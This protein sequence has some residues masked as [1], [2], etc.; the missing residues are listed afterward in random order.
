MHVV[1]L[2]TFC[3][4]CDYPLDGLHSSECPE[5]GQPF[6]LDDL[7]TFNMRIDGIGL[8]RARSLMEAHT[9]R[10]LLRS[11][12]VLATVVHGTFE[13]GSSASVWVD[14]QDAERALQVL[15]SGGRVG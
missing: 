1:S 12:D 7:Q 9:V 2:R 4:E 14:A 6:D 3:A 5:C 13:W 11:H 8:Y 15:A 10:D